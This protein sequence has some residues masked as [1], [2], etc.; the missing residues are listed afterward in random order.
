MIKLLI[1]V[2]FVFGL[3]VLFVGGLI[4]NALR[5]EGKIKREYERKMNDVT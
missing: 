4:F 5:N 3:M 2:A 1:C